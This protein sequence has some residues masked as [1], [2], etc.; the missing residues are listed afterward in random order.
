MTVVLLLL[1]SCGRE[2]DCVIDLGLETEVVSPGAR[3]EIS[4]IINKNSMTFHL[5]AECPYLSRM[6]DGNRMEL[7]VETLSVLLSF[8]YEPCGR[9]NEEKDSEKNILP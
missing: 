6:K 8:G 2:G 5:D 9:C 4:V 3:K 1:S 7:S